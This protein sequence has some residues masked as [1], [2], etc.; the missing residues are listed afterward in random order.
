MYRLDVKHRVGVG[1]KI[2]AVGVPQQARKVSLRRSIRG[3]ELRSIS[4]SACFHM[5]YALHCAGQ[6]SQAQGTNVSGCTSGVFA[7]VLVASAS[8]S[9]QDG[10][11]RTR[12]SLTNLCACVLGASLG[13]DCKSRSYS[14][15]VPLQITVPTCLVDV[16]TTWH[17]CV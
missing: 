6:V 15:G 2:L 11:D 17:Q 13:S 3:S 8:G 10:S 1:Y 4:A 14:A 7:A 16:L 9:C 12:W 5:S